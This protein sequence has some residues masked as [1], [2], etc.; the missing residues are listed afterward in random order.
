MTARES[1][2]RFD[3]QGRFSGYFVAQ[4]GD[5]DVWVASMPGNGCGIVTWTVGENGPITHCPVNNVSLE[6]SPHDTREIAKQR[7]LVFLVEVEHAHALA[8]CS[9]RNAEKAVSD[10]RKKQEACEA[11]LQ[12]RRLRLQEVQRIIREDYGVEVIRCEEK[13]A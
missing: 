12:T 13:R 6:R 11:E 3:T 8:E 5:V 7:G 1:N 10:A 4:C 9:L 2:P